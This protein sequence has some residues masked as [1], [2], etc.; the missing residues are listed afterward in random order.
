MFLLLDL[1][2]G[3]EG[4]VTIERQQMSSNQQELKSKYSDSH[5][6]WIISIVVRFLF[7]VSICFNYKKYNYTNYVDQK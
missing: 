4:N 3:K 7:L 5:K 6:L 2:P 1:K